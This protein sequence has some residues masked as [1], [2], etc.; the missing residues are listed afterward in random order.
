MPLPIVR[1]AKQHNRSAFRCGIES[2]DHY[3]HRQAGQD[4]R[5]DIAA[6]YVLEGD[7]GIEIKGYYTLSAY[8][9]QSDSFPPEMQK[10]C[11][12]YGILPA[13]LLGRLAVDERYQGQ[14][15][16][17]TL[18]VSALKHCVEHHQ[19]IA[20]MVVVVNAINDEVASFYRHFHFQPFPE[21]S[22]K[23][24]IPMK[25]LTKLFGA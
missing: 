10:H 2:L 16:G 25:L 14:G 6:V 11:P 12:R 15:L 1:L 22:D 21:K 17:Q 20:A 13:Y 4:S 3:L 24:F 7:D 23:L 18:L 8:G 5:R 19:S 9:I